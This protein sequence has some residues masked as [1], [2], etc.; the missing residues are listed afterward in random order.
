MDLFWIRGEGPKDVPSWAYMYLTTTLK[1]PPEN[2]SS[3]LSVQ[4][5][6]LWD[7]KLVTFIRIYNPSASEEALVVKNFTSL[8]QHLELIL[9]E[10]YWEKASDR[11]FL[12]RRSTPKPRSQ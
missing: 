11:V 4:K 3:L 9:Y 12:E 8:D 5:V 1:V 2:L 7:G 6:G 10:G